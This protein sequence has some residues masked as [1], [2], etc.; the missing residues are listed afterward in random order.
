MNRVS[1][2]VGRL[3]RPGDDA[4]TPQDAERISGPMD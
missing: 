4:A 1:E 3:R 2:R